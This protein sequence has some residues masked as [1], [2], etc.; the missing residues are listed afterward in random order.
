[1]WSVRKPSLLGVDSE[2]A[3]LELEPPEI[4]CPKHLACLSPVPAPYLPAE[5]LK[6]DRPPE[7]P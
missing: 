1:M 2:L 5:G 4:L 6:V 7:F 3:T